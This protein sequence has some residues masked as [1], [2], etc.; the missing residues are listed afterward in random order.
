[1][2]ALIAEAEAIINS[3]DVTSD[4]ASCVETDL[5]AA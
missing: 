4:E 5:M 3:V 2:D 1:M